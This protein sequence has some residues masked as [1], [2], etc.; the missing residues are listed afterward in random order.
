[1]RWTEKAFVREE[2]E[3]KALRKIEPSNTKENNEESK[4]VLGATSRV[5]TVVMARD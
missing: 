2:D 4:C 1:M 5:A 3:K